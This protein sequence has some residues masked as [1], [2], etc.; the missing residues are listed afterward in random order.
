M[1]LL[2]KY[3]LSLTVSLDFHTY[4]SCVFL[5]DMHSVLGMHSVADNRRLIYDKFD[6]ESFLLVSHK[7][8]PRVGNPGLVQ[9]CR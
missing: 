5:E 2:S 7:S 3:I 8:S 1:V 4:H 6:K 9:Q